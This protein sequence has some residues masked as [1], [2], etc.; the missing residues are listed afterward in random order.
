MSTCVCV[1][2][3]WTRIF[4]N[5]ATFNVS[6]A[7]C[8]NSDTYHSENLKKTYKHF[9]FLQKKTKFVSNNK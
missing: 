2:M 6:H 9:C 5:W 8:L 1:H 3:D 7:E 4:L